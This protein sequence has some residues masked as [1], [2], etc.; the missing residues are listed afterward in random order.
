MSNPSVSRSPLRFLQRVGLAPA[1][2]APRPRLDI[3]AQTVRR[4]PLE[5]PNPLPALGVALEGVPP[6]D[7]AG[8]TPWPPGAGA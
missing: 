7:R 3:D 8:R 5:P 2:K 1:P 6:P 4:I